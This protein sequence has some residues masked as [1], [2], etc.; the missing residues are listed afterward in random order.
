VYTWRGSTLEEKLRVALPTGVR[1][2]AV[3]PEGA[4]AM[5]PIAVATSSGVSV[6]R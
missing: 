1:A 4:S 5:A 3:C 6:I 2:L